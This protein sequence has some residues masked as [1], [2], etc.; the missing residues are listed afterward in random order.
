VKQAKI[1]WQNEELQ[2][3]QAV[4]NL[5]Q[6]VFKSYSDARNAIS[7]Y[8]AALRASNAAQ[9]A[10][11]FAEKRY[12]VGLTNTV[13]YLT[14]RQTQYRAA[15]QLASSKYDLIF[16]LKVVDYYMGKEIRI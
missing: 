13:E 2:R 11:E 7:K 3:A 4:L 16:K 6:S 15:S 12:E 1:Q 5:K 14:T 10:L 8:Q 9:R